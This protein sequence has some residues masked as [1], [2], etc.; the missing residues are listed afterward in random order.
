M[1]LLNLRRG[2]GCTSAPRMIGGECNA[3]YS[4]RRGRMVVLMRPRGWGRWAADLNCTQ[5]SEWHISRE[6]DS[7]KK[8][9]GH[10]DWRSMRGRQVTSRFDWKSGILSNFLSHYCFVIC[11]IVTGKYFSTYVCELSGFGWGNGTRTLS[12]ESVLSQT[13]PSRTVVHPT[14]RGPNSH[15]DLWLSKLW[16]LQ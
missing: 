8:Y 6:C 9:T 1:L 7:E 10:Q 16:D 13:C 15:Q 2:R 12:V 3:L 5:E 11:L 14:E 4:L